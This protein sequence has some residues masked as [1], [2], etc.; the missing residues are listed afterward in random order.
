M[1]NRL[2]IGLDDQRQHVLD[3]S[4]GFLF[5]PGVGPSRLDDECRLEVHGSHDEGTLHAR[6]GC[7]CGP[8]RYR[9]EFLAVGEDDYVVGSSVI[10]PV[11]G[12]RW[13]LAVEISGAVLV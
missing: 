3:K 13:V 12:N 11:V 10:D 9:I 8:N 7:D 2:S 4:F 5:G 1:R 6:M